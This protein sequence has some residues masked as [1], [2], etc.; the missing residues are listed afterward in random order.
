MFCNFKSS[1]ITQEEG[2]PNK[3]NVGSVAMCIY[4]QVVS[5]SMDHSKLKE[6][7]S[8]GGGTGINH[9]NCSPIFGMSRTVCL[10]RWLYV[11]LHCIVL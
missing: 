1:W 10:F 3:T 4:G 7:L 2:M 9:S 5:F 8:E 6:A 11:D